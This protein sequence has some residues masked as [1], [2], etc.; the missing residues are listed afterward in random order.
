MT[1]SILDQ[2]ESSLKVKKV[3]IEEFAESSEYCGRPLYPRQRVL[4]K[5]I[6]L[7]ELTG[8][9]EDI[10]D[11]WINGG[12]GG[13]EI[14]ISRDI[15]K[16]VEVL[17]EN[18]Y[19][20]FTEV[21]LVGGR[22]A[23]K[24]YVT[25]IAMAKVMFDTLQLE[26]PGAHY[27][28]DPTKNIMFSCIA[29]SED[30][31]REYQF[32]DLT[33]TVEGCKAMENNLVKALETE[34]RV[35]TAAD[36]R[37]IAQAKARGGKIQKDIARLRGKA[38]ASNAGTIRGS[39]TMVACIDEMAFML[40]GLS[41][42][43][44][45]AVY[46]ALEPSFDQ[47][48][49]DGLLFCNSSPYTKLGKFYERWELSQTPI[50]EEGGNYRSFGFRY[51]SWALF[52]DYQS[53]ESKWVPKRRMPKGVLTASPDWDEN[54]KN[55]DGTDYYTADDKEQILKA[56][57]KEAAN[58]DAYKVERRGQFAEVV[59][60]YL[61]PAMVDQMYAGK[62]IG[63]TPE[64]KV[65]YE[66]YQADY[67]EGILN[68]YQYRAHLDPSSTT[69]GFGFAMGHVEQFVNPQGAEE[70]HVVFDIIK[71]WQPG[72][73][74]GGAIHWPTVQKEVMQ[75]IRLFRPTMLTLDQYQSHEPIQA[76]QI[77]VRE[78]G[79]DT[80]IKEI[81]ATPEVNWKRAEN[82]KTALY[83]GLVHAPATSRYVQATED[84]KYSALELKFLQEMR[85]ASKY[86]RID[87]PT[88]GEV[89]TKDMA[90]CIMEVTS[91]LLGN[92][93][94]TRIQENLANNMMSTGAPGGYNIGGKDMGNRFRQ[95]PPEIQQAMARRR[96]EQSMPASER[97]P[98]AGL[99]IGRRRSRGI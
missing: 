57:A 16:R 96:G 68:I 48:G 7:E 74:K 77:L 30:Q 70:P 23:S 76:M 20:H 55:P 71:R 97:R 89:K 43:S 66:P 6:F 17:R 54:R 69:A 28:I 60:A 72:E 4:L 67:G 83:Q 42:A 84:I 93:L 62:P 59:D 65:V 92:Y 85:T 22:R 64:L 34:L 94:S 98:R 78:E 33:N 26:D 91:A 39:A 31:A 14:E 63:Y 49:R 46:T 79:L 90:D 40:E 95:T 47:F 99:S 18:N 24:G 1:F 29:G 37:K 87:H 45:E 53:N 27:G 10:L 58:P 50:D 73:F 21:V 75:L 80:Q 41:K 2:V 81:T 8:K 13:N 38:L 56:R 3:G 51:P 12:L 61:N 19:K 25:G 32:N 15:R 86:P 88:V 9:E 36:H 11:Y 52:E 5:L 44:G 82:Y 35:A